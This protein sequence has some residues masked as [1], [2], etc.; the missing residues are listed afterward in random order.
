MEIHI[1]TSEGTYNHSFIKFFES[2]FELNNQ[3]FVFRCKPGGIYK[4]GDEL[5]KRILYINNS[6]KFILLLFHKLLIADKIYIHYFPIGPSLYFWYVSKFLLKKATW[7]LWGGDLYYY[8]YRS[9]NFQSAVY[10]FIRRRVL[11]KIPRIACFIK[12]DYELVKKIYKSKANYAYVVYPIPIDFDYLN[13]IK[14]QSDSNL[15]TILLGNSS[16]PSNEHIAILEALKKF[17]DFNIKIICP[18]S[19]GG[20]NEYAKSIEEYGRNIFGDKFVALKDFIPPEEYA[21]IIKGVDIAIFQHQRQ[22]G[23]GT[24]LSLLYIGAKVFI[25]EEITSFETLSKMGLKLFPI[26][27]IDNLDFKSFIHI[28]NETKLTNKEV[29]SGEFSNENYVKIWKNLFENW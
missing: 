18:L 19:Y 4:Y 15:I 28:D 24:I 6:V 27:K 9:Q 2:N 7:I 10:E 14:I 22:Q 21:K 13:S 11:K 8:K 3:L 23:L 16:D 29:I 5:K 25:R 26:D 17:K 20:E 1:F 12:G